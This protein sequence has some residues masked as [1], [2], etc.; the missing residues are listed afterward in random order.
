MIAPHLLEESECGRES[1]GTDA[2]LY[3]P[4]QGL[5]VGLHLG[6]EPEPAAGEI[7]R[8]VRR[9]MLEGLPAEGADELRVVCEVLVGVGPDPPCDGVADKRQGEGA[10]HPSLL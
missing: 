1:L 3:E 7:V 4:D 9:V 5:F 8:A 10:D 6:R 2:P